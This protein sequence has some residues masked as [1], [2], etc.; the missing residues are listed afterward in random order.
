MSGE[1]YYT[2]L[3]AALFVAAGLGLVIMQPGL[4]QKTASTAANLNPERTALAGQ[5]CAIGKP[6]FSAPFA[7]IDD[8]ISV[9]PLGGVT[10]PGEALPAPYIRINTRAGENALE[11][12]RTNALAPAKA[13]V[14]A[15]ERRIVRG[16]DGTALRQQWT[17][18]F[19]TC[20]NIRFYY[21]DLDTISPD[22]MRRAGGVALMEEVTGP[23]HVA[24]TT[25]VRV[26][27]GEEIGAADGFDVGLI[28]ASLAP[29]D[30]VNPARYRPDPYLEARALHVKPELAKAIS[31]DQTRARC[32]LDY[33]PTDISGKWTAMLG[34]AFGMARAKGANACR[35]AIVEIADA[36]QGSWFT[37]AAH[38]GAATKVSAIAL[39]PDAIDPAREIFALHGRLKSLT[40]DM[41]GLAPYLDEQRAAAAKDFL[42]VERDARPGMTGE[43]INPPFAEVKAGKTYCYDGLRANFVGP[44]I[45]AV[46][47]V[48]LEEEP[49]TGAKLMKME[50][51][52]DKLAC[53]D[54]EEPWAFTGNET[55]F[56]R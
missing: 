35:T 54:L 29:A 15:I 26:K 19:Q 21:D 12:R 40:P 17:V 6:A 10:A 24:M 36:A 33:L 45:N 56:Y 55:V 11:R 14:T 50:A 31:I 2:R 3:G 41:V 49:D 27:A 42:T 23:D 53:I 32:P 4:P 18:Y 34:H 8:V 13:D 37:D 22:L 30:L 7:N 46:L 25:Q 9:S 5:P 52:G 51:R 20:E 47:L 38:N 43:R 1:G 39:A 48:A 16:E 44:R 28:D